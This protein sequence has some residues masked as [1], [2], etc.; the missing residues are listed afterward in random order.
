MGVN[1]IPVQQAAMTKVTRPFP[2]LRNKVWPRET[3]LYLV[4]IRLQNLSQDPFSD[5]A[6]ERSSCHVPVLRLN[7]PV[8][9]WNVGK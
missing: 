3:D 8:F 5:L 4:Q 1:E 9:S 2:L 6:H 7:T